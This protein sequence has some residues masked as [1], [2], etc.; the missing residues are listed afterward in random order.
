MLLIAKTKEQIVQKYKKKVLNPIIL[1]AKLALMKKEK[2][3]E[4][5]TI[6]PAMEFINF[7]KKE[8]DRFSQH[9]FGYILLKIIMN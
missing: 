7:V 5:D 4:I 1:K 9:F 8:I 3:K 2:S 6:F